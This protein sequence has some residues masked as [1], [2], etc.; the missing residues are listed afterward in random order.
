MIDDPELNKIAHEIVAYLES[1]PNASDTLNGVAD[2]WVVKQRYSVV[3]SD[4]KK[5][6][7]YL[8]E[9]KKITTSL[10]VNGSTVYKIIEDEV[11]KK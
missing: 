5:A 7:D 8:Y 6:L 11:D 1:N 3:V 10:D 4:V 2:W 9:T